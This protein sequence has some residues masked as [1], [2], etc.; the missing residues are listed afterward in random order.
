MQCGGADPDLF[1][2]DRPRN[3]GVGQRNREYVSIWADDAPGVLRGRSPLQ[4]YED[5]MV[6]FR[7]AFFQVGTPAPAGRLPAW[8]RP[9]QGL[10]L[11]CQC[12]WMYE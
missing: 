3:G 5:F 6:A 12:M 11:P 10:A 4:C 8:R 1:F 9:E 2:T 7:D